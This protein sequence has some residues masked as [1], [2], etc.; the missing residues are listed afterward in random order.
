VFAVLNL[1]LLG[2]S[3]RPLRLRVVIFR[4]FSLSLLL[5]LI[6][7][8]P[9][10]SH[11]HPHPSSVHRRALADLALSASVDFDFLAI[12]PAKPTVAISH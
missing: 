1:R 12:L 7:P 5:S 9:G 3:P 10:C 11:F 2:E 8:L 6:T 4:A